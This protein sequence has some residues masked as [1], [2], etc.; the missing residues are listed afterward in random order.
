MNARSREEEPFV[1]EEDW[2]SH[3]YTHLLRDSP[4]GSKLTN[5]IHSMFSFELD[6][7]PPSGASTKARWGELTMEEYE[8]F[9][10][11]LRLA[12]QWLE[13]APSNDAI[14]SIIYGDRYIPQGNPMHQGIAISKFRHHGLPPSVVHERA[15]NALKRLGNSI[16]FLIT[17]RDTVYGLDGIH[18]CTSPLSTEYPEGIAI[19]HHPEVKGLA[20]KIRIHKIYI[21]T[22]RRLLLLENNKFQIL[23]LYFEFA[24][25][26]C[27]EVI[28]AV[29]YAVEP[30]LLSRYIDMGKRYSE[31]GDREIF[32]KVRF[33]EPI[34]ESQRV[35]EIGYFWETQVFG[36]VCQ[37]SV[38]NPEKPI[39][40]VD[41][42]L[43]LWQDERTVP[44]RNMCYK[45]LLST[46]YI[47]KSQTQEFWDIVKSEH[48]QDLLA[49]RIR[50]NVAII[51]ELPPG[52]DYDPT[53]DLTPSENAPQLRG[54]NSH[55]VLCDDPEPSPCARLL[56]ETREERTA[57]LDAERQEASPFRE[58]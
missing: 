53:W 57:R 45:Y 13:S 4:V 30:E 1:E 17:E 11:P 46:Y 27:H 58:P 24:L 43:W 48:S 40:L 25:T 26:I 50:R 37:Q 14:C 52:N 41:W 31:T 21:V 9:D 8:L 44:P 6:E 5:D 23:K 39:F 15:G 3:G 51:Y 7:R 32:G 12:T 33:N 19:T 42:P 56:N 38:S 34:Y 18:G 20:S 28:H 2:V 54:K 36:G 29:N 35:A 47:Q 22:L 10:Q 16:S 49:L 55:Q